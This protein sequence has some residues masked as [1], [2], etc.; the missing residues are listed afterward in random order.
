VPATVCV[1]AFESS[2]SG[3]A[4]PTEAEQ[5]MLSGS[6]QQGQSLIGEL[7]ARDTTGTFYTQCYDKLVSNAS[8]RALVQQE[9]QRVDSYLAS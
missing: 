1:F 8:R 5:E 9:D 4:S 3:G 7:R 6:L 2:A